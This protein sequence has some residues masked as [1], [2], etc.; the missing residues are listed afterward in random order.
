[1]IKAVV[2]DLDDTLYLEYD[3]VKSGFRAVA[4]ELKRECGVSDAYGE[5]LRLFDENREKV[6]DRYLA[7]CGAA[8]GLTAKR[9]VEIYRNHTPVLTLDSE[10]AQTL[11]TLREKG[12]KLGIIT[13]G[14]PTRQ[15]V[16]IS[17]LGLTDSVDKII[18]TDELG[19]KEFRK[20]NPKAFELMYEAFGITP[21]QMLYVGDN[22]QK[23][24][25]VKKYLPIKTAHYLGGGLYC[26]EYRDDILPN[27]TVKSFSEI[28]SFA[29][30][31]S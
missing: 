14:E 1:M 9:M 24:F 21:E 2:F 17:A 27:V 3:Y 4:V 8:K 28:E 6:F 13:D 12:Y 11:A 18:V 31:V 5:L 29:E 25:A 7:E 22:P 30:G 23:D 16:K 20:P 10:A 19:G 26:G 15:R